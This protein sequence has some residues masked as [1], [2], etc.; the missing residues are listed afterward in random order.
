MPDFDATPCAV[1]PK[2]AGKNRAF[3]L[4]F[5]PGNSRET[6]TKHGGTRD[7]FRVAINSQYYRTGERKFIFFSRESVEWMIQQHALALLGL[8][9]PWPETATTP[10]LPRGAK[11][12][13]LK[14]EKDGSGVMDSDTGGETMIETFTRTE[15]FQ[16]EHNE[17]KAYVMG[18]RAPVSLTQI[19]PRTR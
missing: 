1:F 10:D 9:G 8:L 2:Q 19:R 17:W 16:D 6:W 5:F 14:A 11:V 18:S 4:R 15:P 3:T 7:N 12:W 13:W